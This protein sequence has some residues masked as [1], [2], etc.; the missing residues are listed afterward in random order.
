M[1]H[2]FRFSY[3]HHVDKILSLHLDVRNALLLA[4]DIVVFW[5]YGVGQGWIRYPCA[6]LRPAVREALL[7]QAAHSEKY[8]MFHCEP[9]L[10]WPTE[11][12]LQDCPVFFV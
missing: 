2:W 10:D 8:K 6:S 12:L 1:K 11:E 5:H 3:C 4:F 7:I 9:T